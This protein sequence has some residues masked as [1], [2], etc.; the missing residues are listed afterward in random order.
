[1]RRVFVKG[2]LEGNKPR[3]TSLNPLRRKPRIERKRGPEKE[4]D[5]KP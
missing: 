2:S 5:P 1:M 3:G 4:A